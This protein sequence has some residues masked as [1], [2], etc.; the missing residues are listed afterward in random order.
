M[1]DQSINSDLQDQ[2]EILTDPYHA[3]SHFFAFGIIE[4]VS[5]PYF[6]TGVC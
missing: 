1:P 6:S 2:T 3:I 5:S 4:S